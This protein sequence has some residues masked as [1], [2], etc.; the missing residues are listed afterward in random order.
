MAPAVSVV[1]EKEK[2]QVASMLKYLVS[3]IGLTP[4]DAMTVAQALFNAKLDS[5]AK[6]S[7]LTEGKCVSIGIKNVDARKLLVSNGK[8]P[9]PAAHQPP[10]MIDLMGQRT[11]TVDAGTPSSKSS[12]SKRKRDS[13]L[14]RPLPAQPTKQRSSALAFDFEEILDE[15]R[16]ETA[17]VVVNRAP[18][19]SAW[20]TVVAERLDFS[21]PEALSLAAAYTEANA[22]SKGVSLG[23][24][25][26]S[27]GRVAAGGP[28]QPYVDL[29]GRRIYVLALQDGTWRGVSKGVMAEPQTSF[30]YI[31]RACRQ[32]TGVVVG[33]MRLLAQSF[34]DP[35]EL[36]RVG[37][38]L[39]ADFRPALDD[40]AQMG[41]GKRAEVKI[42]AILDLRRVPVASETAVNQA[43]TDNVDE[44]DALLDDDLAG[45]DDLPIIVP[46]STHPHRASVL[47]SSLL[48]RD[49]AEKSQ[50]PVA[51]PCA[52]GLS[53]RSPTVEQAVR[54]SASGEVLRTSPAVE[55]MTVIIWSR[56]IH[57]GMHAL[58]S[59]QYVGAIP[60]WSGNIA[61]AKSL[62]FYIGV[63]EYLRK[64]SPKRDYIIRRTERLAGNGCFALAV[65]PHHTQLLS[66]PERYRARG[67]ACL[68]EHLHTAAF[69]VSSR[70]YI[71]L[72]D[73][74]STVAALPP[75]RYHRESF[76]DAAIDKRR[77]FARDGHAKLAIDS[78]DW[79]MDE[80]ETATSI[81]HAPLTTLGL[82]PSRSPPMSRLTA[83][84]LARPELTSSVGDPPFVS[85]ERI[86]RS[87]GTLRHLPTDRQVVR[88]GSSYQEH[89]SVINSDVDAERWRRTAPVSYPAD[90]LGTSSP[91]RLAA[92][93]VLPASN[94]V[95]EL[96][97]V[98]PA[99]APALGTAF[100]SRTISASSTQSRPSSME[101]SIDID[102]TVAIAADSEDDAPFAFDADPSRVHHT[103][104]L[105]PWQRRP[106]LLG[107]PAPEQSTPET[108][109]P[110]VSHLAAPEMASSRPVIGWRLRPAGS[111]DISPNL[112]HA[113]AMPRPPLRRN[114]TSLASPEEI[115]S[116]SSSPFLPRHGAPTAV[117]HPQS[118]ALSDLS[119][120][121]RRIE[122][123][124]DALQATRV[125]LQQAN[126]A[127]VTSGDSLRRRT[128]RSES[129]TSDS[130]LWG[131]IHV[132]SPVRPRSSVVSASS[133]AQ[134]RAGGLG[135]LGRLRGPT[136][137]RNEQWMRGE[138]LPGHTSLEPAPAQTSDTFDPLTAPSL[139]G[140]N[141]WRSDR[142]YSF[143]PHI[144]TATQRPRP[145]TSRLNSA[146]VSPRRHIARV[147][148][149]N[150]LGNRQTS[151]QRPHN[152]RRVRSFETGDS[153]PALHDV[154]R[155]AA[156]SIDASAHAERHYSPS[157]QGA[158]HLR[159]REERSNDIATRL[160]ELRAGRARVN[161]TRGHHPDLDALIRDLA[162]PGP[163]DDS[164]E[165]LDQVRA[166]DRQYRSDVSRSRGSMSNQRHRRALRDQPPLSSSE[167][168]YEAF[169]DGA[170]R[171]WL[172][173][174]PAIFQRLADELRQVDFWFGGE[175]NI[176]GNL[177]NYMDDDSL[178][179][180]YEALLALAD[181]VDQVTPLLKGYSSR[182]INALPKFTYSEI[183]SG[184]PDVKLPSETRCSICLE[185]YK[186]TDVL[187]HMAC[188]HALHEPCLDHWLRL[189]KSCPFCRQDAC[190]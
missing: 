96:A 103:L 90:S 49:L 137:S 162:L 82:R 170:I 27:E 35:D 48:P 97:P 155:A 32:Q 47:L 16:L 78:P 127:L 159:S 71:M 182:R 20:A 60:V 129:E 110:S 28:A 190:E 158:R 98:T 100:D 144:E 126:T 6:M 14:D 38:G 135:T 149:T 19:M 107:Q 116:E 125:S 99:F 122:A 150:N 148:D 173:R 140:R 163:R 175:A 58:G 83:Q 68:P 4:A 132:A 40:S 45:L 101:D 15:E 93:F 142:Q 109:L 61:D 95:D 160:A 21:R 12:A 105:R 5:V 189:E 108:W 62:H 114:A 69:V 13:D 64:S 23:I 128:L 136:R 85:N 73:H 8:K 39:Y 178:D 184:M 43:K 141:P 152:F 102:S 161:G 88:R 80:S 134:R 177:E 44:F 10:G 86:S 41:W 30:D 117:P 52:D 154:S 67:R 65:I 57:M 25:S 29:L 186:P 1:H 139:D 113:N 94:T 188:S 145:Q 115:S 55:E 51:A 133:T 9:K 106:L 143:A 157:R 112:T 76:C 42:K 84:T 53:K 179:T 36:N 54:V 181:R 120:T 7:Q 130:G 37:F 11:Q 166:I 172:M 17:S 185:E 119:E 77:Q 156:A 174:P 33:A 176:A 151:I 124:V 18:I 147:A 87:T 56:L 91:P 59:S 153:T 121:R 92:A 31:K 66:C 89:V 187:L 111:L 168:S 72:F 131:D 24:I 46:L 118:A 183:I 3:S 22:T 180:S 50:I 104:P 171:P 34:T 138:P 81:E 74:D 79:S 2:L 123:S 164:E 63:D 165:I 146:E 169:A 75:R 167:A 26:A 70:D